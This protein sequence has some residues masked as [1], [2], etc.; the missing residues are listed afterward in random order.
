MNPAPPLTRTLRVIAPLQAKQSFQRLEQAVAPPGLCGLLE[1]QGRLVQKLVQQRLAEVL[2]LSAILGAQMREAAQR[3]LQLR[4]AHLVQPLAELLQDGHDDQPAVPR[5]EALDLFAHDALRR[6]DVA[7][8]LHRGL[9]GHRLEIVDV[10]QEDVLEL[11]DRG[12]DIARHPEIEDA[13]GTPPAPSDRGGYMVPGDDGVRRRSRAPSHC[14]P[15]RRRAAP[16]ETAGAIWGPPGPS[17]SPTRPAPAPGSGIR[18][19]SWRRA[20]RRRGTDDARH[21]G[22]GACTRTRWR[23]DHRPGAPTESPTPPPARPRPPRRGRIPSDCTWKAARRRARRPPARAR[24]M[25]ARRAARAQSARA[26]RAGPYGG[27]RPER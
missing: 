26:P 5:P 10:V 7:A 8:A 24:V 17:T 25:P 27:S 4:G 2:D 13:Q 3:A 20:P 9:C 22:P 12:L 19:G 15:G 21:P 11:R 23:C 18:R 6:R 14:A 16:I 1:G